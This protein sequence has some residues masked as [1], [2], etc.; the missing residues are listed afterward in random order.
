MGELTVK[1]YNKKIGLKR[2][3]NAVYKTLNQT[4]DITVELGFMGEEDMRELNR[5]TRGVD[6][7]TDVLSFPSLEGIRG[8][9]LSAKD[10]PY[11]V[12]EDGKIFLGSIILC[13]ER[14]K[15]QAEEL[16]HDQKTE[17]QYLIVHGLM[18]LFGYDHVDEGEDKKLM[19]EKEKT[20]LKVLGVMQ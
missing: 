13:E 6:K 4:A 2:I 3:A 7:V 11:D 19:R 20:A 16:G 1:C 10:Y 12:D 14:I 15:Q 17:R 8:K 5:E 9:V 18:H